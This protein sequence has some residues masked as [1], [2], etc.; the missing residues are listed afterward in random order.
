MVDKCSYGVGGTYGEM[1]DLCASPADPIFWMHHANLDQVWWLWQMRNL[2]KRLYDISGLINLMDHT[3]TLGGN[4][5]LSFPMTLGVNAKNTTVGQTMNIKG[6]L[7][8][9]YD[10]LY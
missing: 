10:K 1:E 6:V 3:N 2:P 9:D 5:T 7:C 8:Y 4:V